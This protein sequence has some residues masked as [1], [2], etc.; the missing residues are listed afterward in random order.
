MAAD[1]TGYVTVSLNGHPLT[2][3][4]N[5]GGDIDVGFEAKTFAEGVEV[6]TIDQI[7]DSITSAFDLG[8]IQS[9]IDS[10][11]QSLRDAQ[12]GAIV[13]VFETAQ[14]RIMALH[15]KT[16]PKLNSFVF[17]LAVDLTHTSPRVGIAG[18]TLDAFGFTVRASKAKP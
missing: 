9:S 7:I 2:L 8:D 13:D 14:I 4:G 16:T 1:I 10:V 11:K 12:L 17:G 3:P 18:V 6:G 5:V 15:I